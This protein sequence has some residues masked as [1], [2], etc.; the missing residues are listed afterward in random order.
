MTWPGDKRRAGK[1]EPLGWNRVSFKVQ[2][3]KD[4]RGLEGGHLEHAVVGQY[5][6]H[7]S[8]ARYLGH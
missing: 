2:C 7:R 6:Q 1:V 8:Q 3:H 5:K 4:L